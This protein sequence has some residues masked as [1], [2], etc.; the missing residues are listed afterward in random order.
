M[1]NRRPH[2]ALILLAALLGP[3]LLAGCTERVDAARQELAE[4]RGRL[5][6]AKR[7]A[8]ELKAKYE[9]ARARY[10]RVRSLTI[11]REERV[12]LTLEPIA[13]PELTRLTFLPNATRGGVPVPAEN[14][15]RLPFIAVQ[16]RDEVHLGAPDEAGQPMFGCD[17]AACAIALV[18]GIV[19]LLGWAE[20]GV[21]TH[22]VLDDGTL[23]AYRDG[24]WEVT[25]AAG[26]GLAR[27]DAEVRATTSAADATS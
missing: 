14:I 12:D 21:F 16:L 17:P 8:Q 23:L 7:E 4:A 11:V 22:Q 1:T 25:D 27:A 2:V 19:V 6:E 10:E 15:T 26:F 9:E 5:D 3:A 24:S 13:D 20:D 18:P